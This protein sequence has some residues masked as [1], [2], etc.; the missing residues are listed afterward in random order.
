NRRS[1]RSRATIERATWIR[2]PML[3]LTSIGVGGRR[4]RKI[5]EARR[6]CHAAHDALRRFIMNAATPA[7]GLTI[8]RAH[9]RNRPRRRPCGSMRVDAETVR[10]EEPRSAHVVVLGNEKGGS[11]KSTTAMHVAVA[12]MK[13]GQRV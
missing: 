11:G 5:T 2:R 6:G 12:L 3:A 10:T 1:A 13:A 7:R 9:H 4:G 8:A